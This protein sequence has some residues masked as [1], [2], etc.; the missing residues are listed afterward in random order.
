MKTSS[1][2]QFN[3][4]IRKIVLVSALFFIPLNII[5]QESTEKELVGIDEKLGETVN[6]DYTFTTS[7]GKRVNIAELITKPTIINFVYFE[8]PGICTPILNGLQ[9][10]VSRLDAVPGEDYQILTISFNKDENYLLAKRKKETYLKGL[11]IPFPE[12][13]WL[14]MTGDSV[15]IAGVTN[16]LGFKFKRT[17]LDFAHSAALILLSPEQKVTRYLYGTYQ[18]PFDVKMAIIE[19]SE[20]VVVPSIAKILKFCFSY[21]PDGRKYVFNFLK[22]AAT[23]IIIVVIAFVFIVG[24]KKNN[25]VK[26]ES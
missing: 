4:L 14:W 19:S 16:D 7:E 26:L 17:E 11:G 21:D 6:L 2:W 12:K 18:N 22:I 24:F 9:K 8:C 3:I 1:R 25:K 15:N 23:I 20:G 5:A 10:A 13:D